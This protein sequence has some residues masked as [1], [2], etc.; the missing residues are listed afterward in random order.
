[1]KVKWITVAI[2]GLVFCF[3]LEN[4][5][6][7]RTYTITQTNPAAPAEVVM[8]STVPITF[9][10]TNTANGGNA[11]ERI[12]EMRFRMLSGGS[13][14]S[15]AT[16]APAG[17]TRTAYS[18]TSVTFRANSWANAISTGNF[19]DFTVNLIMRTTTADVATERLRDSRARY[20]T[21][22]TGPPF[23]RLASVTINNPGSWTIKSL[24]ASIQITDTLGNPISAI[25]AGGSFRVVMTVT[26]RSSTTQSSIVVGNPLNRPVVNVLSGAVPGLSLTSTQY[27]PNPLTLAAGATGTITFTYSTA[28]GDSGAVTFSAY[29]RNSTGAATSSTMTSSSLAI[30]RFIASVTVNPTCAYNAQNIAPT[31]L[32]TNNFSGPPPTNNISG[33]TPTL[34]PSGGAPIAFQSGPTP[35]APNGPVLSGGGTFSFGWSYQISGGTPGQTFTF[36]GSATAT[37]GPSLAT[38]NTT[39]AAVTVGGYTFSI[40]PNATNASSSNEAISWTFTNQGCAAVTSVSISY[41]AG[42]SWGGDAYALVENSAGNFIETWTFSPSG[43]NTGPNTVVFTSPSVAERLMQGGAGDFRLVFTATPTTT[44]ASSFTI[45][46]T[47]ANGRT[48]TDSVPITVN[49]FNFNLMNDASTESYREDFR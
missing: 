14:F 35:G 45:V 6:A 3:W 1:M 29:A 49:A 39:S 2:V 26:N 11:G 15:S 46:T 21:T 12:Y 33:V 8:G 40:T 10:I 7:A 16:A 27:T 9:R 23:T 30:S 38:P 34:T 42:W 24:Q 47:D 31:M 41:P 44:G 43:P 4:A 48:D 37:S 18:T 19:L 22:T 25:Q 32:L 13:I 17:W 28:A 36:N 20:T 5:E